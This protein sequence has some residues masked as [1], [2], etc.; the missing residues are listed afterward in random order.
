VLLTA[1]VP[2]SNAARAGLHSGDVLLR[3]QDRPLKTAADLP[4]PAPS[5]E[6][7][8]RV[9]VEVWRAGET[10][11]VEVLPGPLGVA[12]A[13]ESAPEALA[14]RRRIEAEL[15]A[16]R[17]DGA[18][19]ALPGTR[20]EVAALARRFRGAG[21]PLT[22][23]TDSDA[24]EQRL[25]ELAAD[26]RLGQVRYLH[27]ATHGEVNWDFPLQSALVLSRDGLPD[28]A[29]QLDAGRPVYTGRLTAAEVLRDWDLDAELVTLSAC[30]TGLGHYAEGEGYLGF[31]QALL[32]CGSR[33]VVLSLWQVD[34]AATALLMD[35]F[36]ANL[37]GQRD[38]LTTG[39]AKA[40]ALA[41][42]K[43]WLRALPRSEAVKRAATLTGGVERGAG[44][45]A[46]PRAP[47]VPET[48]NDEPPYAHPYYWAA[49]VLVGDPD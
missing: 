36:Y 26:G 29:Q 1:V 11:R 3:Y 37:L 45:E 46:L 24:S 5:E 31:A 22:L 42:A 6:T 16:S 35:R 19:K 32:L 9:P 27:L 43:A 18:W 20:V 44:R 21:Q 14:R 28:P 8:A 30:D 34:D 23:L 7:K 12:L 25:G 4:L 38:G 10:L 41:E 40:E 47:T 39:M 13:R 33:S 2:G 49:F 17:G 15:V 48:A